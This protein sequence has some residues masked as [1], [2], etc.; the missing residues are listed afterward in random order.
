MTDSM[1]QDTPDTP[2]SQ[3]YTHTAV[4]ALLGGALIALGLHAATAGDAGKSKASAASQLE[5]GQY[6]VAIG[7]CND[8]HTPLKMGPHGPEPDMT[9]MLSGHPEGLTMPPAP[10]LPEGPWVSIGSGTNTAFA[11]P[12]GVSFA[13]NLTPDKET[14]LGAWD[15]K[16]FVSALRTGKHLGAGRPIMPPMPWPAYRNMT[17]EDLQAVYAFLRTVP[18]IKNRIPD[19]VLPAK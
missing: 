13:I 2:A 3:R 18:P 16:A 7:G 12:W 11:G 5:R 15:E 8:C 17:D 19:V 1:K 10:K 6:L 4:A 9:R 14:G